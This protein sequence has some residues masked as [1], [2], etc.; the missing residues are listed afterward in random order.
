MKGRMFMWLMLTGL[1]LLATPVLAGA[2]LSLDWW[3]V[4]GGGMMGAR[5][6]TL[7]LGG[8]AGQPD[9]GILTRD[10]LTL[11]GGFWRMAAEGTG[12]PGEED[13]VPAIFRLHAAA[14]NPF[15]P[16]TTLS[17]DLP[18]ARRC[19]LA[20]Y[21][22]AGRRLRVLLDGTLPAG[23]QHIDWDGRDEAGCTMG[24]G[25]YFARIQ[26]GPE[27]ATQKLILMK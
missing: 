10:T 6:G 15:N 22:L 2:T 9:A 18:A 21:A 19:R 1:V 8:T 17:F 23:T 5:A 12:L 24:S 16:K 14:P 3:T 27:S 7:A 13:G 4:D 20:I 11:S 25:V 26:A